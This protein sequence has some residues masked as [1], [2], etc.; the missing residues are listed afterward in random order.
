MRN[1]AKLVAHCD[2]YDALTTR[3]NQRTTH[4]P[5][6]DTMIRVFGEDQ[7]H[8]TDLLIARGFVHI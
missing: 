4:E 3:W 7:A 5:V 6:R 1:H 2:F 8:R